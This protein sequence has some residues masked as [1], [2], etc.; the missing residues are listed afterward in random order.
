MYWGFFGTQVRAQ[1]NTSRTGRRRSLVGSD[2]RVTCVIDQHDMY[3]HV[4]S[5]VV[6]IRVSHSQNSR[7]FTITDALYGRF[8]FDENL[9]CGSQRL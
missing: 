9:K 6:D 8:S 3:K 5:Q 2:S 1:E 7:G 4:F